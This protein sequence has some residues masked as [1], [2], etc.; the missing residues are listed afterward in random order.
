MHDDGIGTFLHD[1]YMDFMKYVVTK[2]VLVL[3]VYTWKYGN[4]VSIPIDR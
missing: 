3:Y 4:L 1:N 2:K